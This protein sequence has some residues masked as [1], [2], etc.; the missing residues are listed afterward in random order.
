MPGEVVLEPF[1]GSGTQIIAAEKLSRRCRAIEIAPAYVGVAAR[2]W[3][4][5]AG[6]EAVLEETGQAFA[7]VAEQRGKPA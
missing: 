1:S 2:R 5:A 3:Q 7:A 6:K 4:L